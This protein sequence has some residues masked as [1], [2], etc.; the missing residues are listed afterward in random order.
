M[1]QA[2]LLI[3]LEVYFYPPL[4][5]IGTSIQTAN[6]KNAFCLGDFIFLSETNILLM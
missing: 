4:S 3:A 2:N 5:S 1:L 6:A